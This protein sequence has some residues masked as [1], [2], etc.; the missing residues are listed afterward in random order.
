V[1]R[2]AVLVQDHL[3]VLRVVDAALAEAQLVLRMIG[4]ERV[5]DAPLVD[6]HRLGPVVDR[7]AGLAEAEAV[8]VLLR[9]GDPVVRHRLLELVLVACV[10]E[11]VRRRVSRVT[12]LADHGRVVARQ[13][14]C[15][16][17]VRQLER[18]NARLKEAL[19][20]Y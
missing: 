18:Q 12:G 4:R 7:T 1:D 16:V 15:A 20:R 9:L 8:D 19:V 14:S 13:E 2:V 5:V 6:P 10:V 17:E 3:G 11:R